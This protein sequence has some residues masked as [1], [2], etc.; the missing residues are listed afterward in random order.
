MKSGSD[1]HNWR[2]GRS[3]AS[4]GYMLVRVGVGHPMADVRGYA[5]A[6]RIVA[7]EKIGRMLATVEHVHHVDGDKLNNDPANLEVHASLAEHFVKHRA[8][9]VGLRLP[10]QPNDRVAC[11][12]GCGAEIERFDGQG[13]PRRF[14]S[15]HNPPRRSTTDAVFAALVAG[16]TTRREIARVTGKPVGSV[17][18]A[19]TK[20]KARGLAESVAGAWRLVRRAA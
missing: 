2:G 8:R 18:S 9:D 4:N 16:L 1:N 12:C 17:A 10:G 3:I 6:H 19:L 15:G 20:L 13:R 14:V 7:A 11:A 5:Y